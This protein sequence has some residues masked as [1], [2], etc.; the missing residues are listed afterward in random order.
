M[1]GELASVWGAGDWGVGETGLYARHVEE[2][3]LDALR[4]SRVVFLRGARQVGKTTLAQRVGRG[5]AGYRT[6]DDL[7]TLDSAR[8]DPQGF[9][10]KLDTPVVLD[11]IQRCPEIY[12][13][14]KATVDRDQRPGR[15]LL[16][17]SAGA[18]VLPR[19]ADAMVGRMRI[20]TLHPLSQGEIEGTREDFID[21]LF[22]DTKWP[23]LAP[24]DVWSRL[25]RG[26][27]PEAV[28]LDA[29]NRASWLDSHVDTV[30]S[31]DVQE[32]AG[33]TKLTALPDLLRLAA[34]RVG[35]L[36]NYSELSRATALPQTTLK[37]Y[38]A[39]L[40]A[41]FLLFRLWPWSPNLGKRM[42][43]SPKL[44]FTDVGLAAHLVNVD[45]AALKERTPALGA[46]LESFVVA[47]IL[48]QLTWS[49]TRAHPYHFRT[50]DGHEVDLVLEGPA[51][52]CVAIEVKATG[53]PRAAD[54]GGLARLRDALGSRFVRGV[55]LHLGSGSDALPFGERLEALPVCALW[56]TRQT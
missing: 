27:Y 2:R 41:T 36:L 48:R 47:E 39:L 18:L 23:S 40:E 30:I 35:S 12:L 28:R 29:G 24:V 43:R 20:L 50:H 25:E 53:T 4:T 6:F 17:G 52:R 37:R 46:L 54:F 3:L 26:G 31:R 1:T 34:A 8:R 13:P 9:V 21:A 38:L 32:M 42:V 44:Y 19:L 11:E 22:S 7:K 49:R 5:V 16:T 15:F 45:A 33:I 14:L 56:Q 10:A 55:L 51:G